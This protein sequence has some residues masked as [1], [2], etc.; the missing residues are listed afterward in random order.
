MRDVTAASTAA[1]DES[2]ERNGVTSDLYWLW[3]LADF[4]RW[5]LLVC[6]PP[7]NGNFLYNVMPIVH[8]ARY[9][10]DSGFHRQVEQRILPKPD[11]T[12]TPRVQPGNL[13][14]RD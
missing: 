4:R 1:A 10:H 6:Q 13:T 3:Y 11:K 9:T 8:S 7:G 2:P 5:K 12:R 14:C